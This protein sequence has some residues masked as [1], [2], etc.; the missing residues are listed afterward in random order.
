MLSI[1][2]ILMSFHSLCTGFAQFVLPLP[3]CF[4]ISCRGILFVLII[5]YFVNGTSINKKQIIGIVIGILGVTLTSNGQLITTLI[6][7]S[8]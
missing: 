2:S 3:V 1:R 4:T 7:P 8:Y 5:D 6:D